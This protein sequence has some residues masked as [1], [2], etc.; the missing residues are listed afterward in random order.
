MD[1]RVTTV[2]G[3]SGFIGR[4]LVRRLAAAGGEIRVAVRNP[5][6]AAHLKPLGDAGQLVLWRTE[7]TDA[8]QVATAVAGAD[9]VV[10][11]VGIL[12]ESGRNTFP[13]THTEAAGAVASAARAAGVKRL[14]HVS[15]IG[16]NA[17]SRAQYALTKAAGEAL[18]MDIFSDVT[19]VRPS[20]V[21]GQED[22]FF[23]MFAGLTRLSPILPLFGCPQL[24]K[25]SFTSEDG[26]ISLSLDL[27]GDGG[28]KFQPVY[29]GD[30]AEAITVILGDNATRGKHYELGGPRVYSFKQI[31]ELVLKHTGR[32]R[33]LA[34]I[35]FGIANFEAWFLEKLPKPLLT[36]DQVELMKTD[37]VVAASALGFAELGLEP[38]AL[39]VILPTYMHRFRR[40][41]DRYPHPA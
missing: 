28:T 29:V 37:N 31:M 34:P 35:P 11:L 21:F 32:R 8:A 1:R 39:E 23:N 40:P 12:Y 20:V 15:A 25:V 5:E 3:G 18:V 6:G 7:I 2:F 16:A 27:Y 30:V 14:V 26:K 17:E 9:T 10:N 38:T 41:A 22:N 36:R 19:I 4:H 24:P 33:V 13:A